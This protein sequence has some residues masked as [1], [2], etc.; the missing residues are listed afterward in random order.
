MFKIKTFFNRFKILKVD[1]YKSIFDF[2]TGYFLS[3]NKSNY[4]KYGPETLEV[5]IAKGNCLHQCKF[6]YRY[7]HEETSK[8]MSIEDF[9]LLISKMPPTLTQISLG[10]TG[11]QSNPDTEA[12]IDYCNSLHIKPNITL[13]GIDLTPELAKRLVPKLGGIG[14]SIYQ[15]KINL[16]FNTLYKIKQ[17]GH[18]QVGFQIIVSK[19]TLDFTYYII[20]RFLNE[21]I[22]PD[23]LVLI[24]PKPVKGSNFTL[25]DKDEY[26]NLIKHCIKNKITI[27]LDQCSKPRLKHV[28]SDK[29]INDIE[30]CE[31]SFFTAFIDVHGNYWHCGFSE[32]SN[33]KIHESFNVFKIDKFDDI[34]NSE[35]LI[36]LRKNIEDNKVN[37]CR[38]CPLFDSINSY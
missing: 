16:A 21:N 25:L 11:I 2:K 24:T 37:D 4:S 7:N 29:M 3:K 10:I 13:T 32:I 36:N 12:I 17:L 8:N 26:R 1:G 6:C 5:E 14:I 18:K 30:S 27:G 22:K 19:E 9:K 31:C 28:M 38:L 35:S 20:D 34:W 23:Y 33:K 15:D